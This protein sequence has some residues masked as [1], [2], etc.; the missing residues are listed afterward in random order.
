[1]IIANGSIEF[2]AKSGGGIDP[3]TGFPIA[4]REQWGSPISAQIIPNSSNKLGRYN[5]ERFTT[6][7]Y[8]VLL[9]AQPLP[10]SERVRLKDNLGNVIGEFSLLSN[11]E[12]LDAVGQIK[13]LV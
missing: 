1:M 11:P 9:E 7:S 3:T 4:V 2:K 13:L 12:P 6:A 10:E 5:G 8:V